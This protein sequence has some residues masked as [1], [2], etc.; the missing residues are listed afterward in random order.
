MTPKAP[1]VFKPMTRWVLAWPD[2][3]HVRDEGG[4][5]L[6]ET[7]RLAR[8]D[9]CYHKNPVRPQPVKVRVTVEVVK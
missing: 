9:A 6:Y 8:E 7:L 2:G 1:L 4:V 5:V 3:S